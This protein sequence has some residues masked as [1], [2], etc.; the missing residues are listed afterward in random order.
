MSPN[1][2]MFGVFKKWLFSI[3]RRHKDGH[4]PYFL[5]VLPTSVNET[6]KVKI[7]LTAVNEKEEDG[8]RSILAPFPQRMCLKKVHLHGGLPLA[9]VLRG[10]IED[11]LC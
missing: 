3:K 10:K 9:L 4:K 8:N 7:T 2:D 5:H 11:P 6:K 1:F